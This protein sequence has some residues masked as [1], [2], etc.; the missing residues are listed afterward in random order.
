M[1]PTLLKVT[2]GGWMNLRKKVFLFLFLTAVVSTF[3]S[4]KT[5]IVVGSKAFSESIILGEIISILLEE[6]MNQP[7]SRRFNLG[8]TQVVFSSLKK[9]IIDVYAEY[10]GTGYSMILN[11]K[12]EKNPDKVYSIVQKEFQKK[13]GIVWSETIGFNNTYALAVR[14]DDSRFYK[15]VS[16]SDLKNLSLGLMYAAPHEFMERKDGHDALIEKYDLNFK[17]VLS[18]EAGLM[19]PAISNKKID[20]A[21]VYSTDG[22]VRANQ[23]KI[24]KDDKKFFPPY[25]V[26]LIAKQ[27]TLEK[28]PELK[29]VFKMVEN[30][31]TEEEMTVLN[32]KADRLKLEPRLIALD[33]LKKKNMISSEKN[34]EKASQPLGSFWKRGAYLVK[35]VKE[36]LFLTFTALILSIL[37]SVPLGILMTRSKKLSKVVFPIIN[38]IQ[39]IPSLALLGFLIPVMGIGMAPAIFALFLYSLLPI[40][41]NTY[42]GILDIESIYIEV[43]KGMGLTPFQI[44]KYVELPLALPIIIAGV[45]TA[46]VVSVGTAVLAAFIGAG[47]LGD[48]IFRGISTLNSDLILL[49]A[50]P[51]ALLAVGLDQLIG[52]LSHFICK[53]KFHR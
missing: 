31:I 39:T 46:V 22:R 10:T 8:G 26:S 28:F 37:F 43:S 36:H 52:L 6:K 42:S 14:Q 23:L 32:N 51:A 7:V 21:V 50:V 25:Y 2:V 40:I 12:G 29:K 53:H 44:L 24:L 13:W 47:G 3:A 27:K 34:L 45:R 20:V 9:N 41:R 19:Y 48:P 17:Q 11:L 18:M 15:T 30:L 38:T 4:E 16:I 5:P 33:F 1:F 49:G 35:L